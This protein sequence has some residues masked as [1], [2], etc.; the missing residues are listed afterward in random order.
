MSNVTVVAVADKNPTESYLIQGFKAFN[1]SLSNFG[2]TPA[3]LGW[4]QKWKG[5]GSKPKLLK[6]AIE[7]GR[8][9][10]EWVIFADAFD[11]AF[12]DSPEM[13]VAVARDEYPDSR[14]TWNGERNLFPPSPERLEG[15]P[16]TQYPYRFFN[17]GLSV[18]RTQDYL[19]ALTE[20]K[21]D[22]KPDD[23]IKPDG[24]WHHEND[25]EWW[26]EKFLFGQCAPHEL[27]MQ[28][29]HKCVLFQTMVEESMDHFTLQ[30]NGLVKN[31]ITKTRPK[32]WHWN[33]GAKTNGT[34]G[35]IL[36]HL[37]LL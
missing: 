23:Y 1:K 19:Q 22:E 7:E 33:G 30:K 26:M 11:V 14:I 17:S 9:E 18:G 8:I 36:N 4:G 3:I 5:L 35:P 10:S 37:D 24:K 34:M 20:M 15:H 13:I 6:K 29:D 16:S 2:H 21:V 27:K 25:Q 32:A 31:I 28:I 12:S